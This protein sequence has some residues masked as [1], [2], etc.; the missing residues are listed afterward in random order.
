MKKISVLICVLILTF[1][2]C[3][4]AATT[5]D[6]NLIDTSTQDTT[7]SS[8]ASSWTGNAPDFT[9][10]RISGGTFTLSSLKG[11]VIILDFWAT[12]CPPCRMEIPGFVELY[13]NYRDQGLEIVGVTMDSEGESVIV[14]FVERFNINYKLVLGNQEIADLY[15]G[16]TGIPTTFII[17]RDGNIVNKHIGFATKEVFEDEIRKLL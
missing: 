9:L 6:N 15:G 7:A 14:P 17:D 8:N 16:I 5:Q 13:K 4:K 3:K 10:P 1:V 11:K 12:W 2:A